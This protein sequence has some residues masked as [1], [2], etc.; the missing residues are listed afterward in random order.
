VNGMKIIVTYNCNIM[1]SNCR[2][3]CAPYKK[4]IMDVK[5]FHNKFSEAYNE[6]YKDYLV[7][8]GGE[9]FMHTGTIFK[10]LK[11]ISSTAIKKTIVTNGFWGKIDPYVNILED[12][13]GLGVGEIVIEYDF[14]HAAFIDKSI[15]IEAVQKVLKSG[16]NVSI[17][18]T[19]NTGN[20]TEETD[21]MT[22]GFIKEVKGKFKGVN[23]ILDEITTN[24]K[25]LNP[26]KEKIILYKDNSK[27]HS[28]V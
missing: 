21:I 7:I 22:F 20:L 17:R 25:R 8:E 10:Y 9:V 19:F 4:G 12:L 24:N 1:C 23:F 16:L 11:K 13:K 2:Y 15:I 18:S 27:L 14:Q 5:E 26:N 6:G 28:L 3:G